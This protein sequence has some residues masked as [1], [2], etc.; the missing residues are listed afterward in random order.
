MN[1]PCSDAL[2]LIKLCERSRAVSDEMRAHIERL[3]AWETRQPTKLEAVLPQWINKRTNA[4]TSTLSITDD[5]DV[6]VPLKWS[7]DVG[8]IAH[9]P[10]T[11]TVVSSDTPAVISG[12]DVAA[13]AMSVVL[14]TVGDGTANVT[15]SNG[16]LSTIIAVTVGAPVPSSLEADTVDAVPV[17]KGTPA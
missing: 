14:R 17:P 11:G 3:I 1:S 4:M 9:P 2:L 16:A 7:D 10:L 12:G 13:D 15:I 8:P 5:H 6:R